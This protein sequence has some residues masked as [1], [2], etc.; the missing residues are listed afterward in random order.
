VSDLEKRIARLEAQAP[1]PARRR[2]GEPDHP[3]FAAMAARG[4]IAWSDDRGDWV[5]LASLPE[6]ERG[7]AEECDRLAPPWWAAPK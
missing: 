1:A 2:P 6:V 7:Y 3:V 4:L 5:M